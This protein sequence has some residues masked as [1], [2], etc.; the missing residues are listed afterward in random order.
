MAAPYKKGTN[1]FSKHDSYMTPKSA[2]ENIKQYIP[3]DKTIWESAYGD[4][5]SGKNLTDLGFN[6]IHRELDYFVDEPENWDIQITN[7]PYTLKKEW[8]TRAKETSKPFI[9]LMPCSVIGRLYF[10]ELFQYEKIQII[11]P[12]KR[13]QF[14]K[15]V[16]GEV[17]KDFKPQC[18]FDC[19]YFC[20]R[21]DLPQ[22]I[23]WLE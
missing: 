22:D 16:N 10:M 23:M 7:P 21:M 12:R 4:G 3:K 9:L 6:V 1:T 19:F 14:V 11:I 5:S 13:I 20:W 17:P 2:W 18:S 15:K 8:L